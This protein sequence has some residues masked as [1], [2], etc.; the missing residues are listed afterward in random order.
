MTGNEAQ[1]MT[2]NEAQPMTGNEAQPMIRPTMRAI[3]PLVDSHVH[4]DRYSDD[5]VMTMLERAAE[6]GVTRLLTV[7]VDLPTSRAALRLAAR[8]P[9]VLAAVGIHP[10]RLAPL[11]S[12]SEP[13]EA[14]QGLVE[15][16][17]SDPA[18]GRP[19]AIGEIG[20]DDGAPDLAV[21]AR[22][23]DRC[24]GLAADAQLPV[25]LHVVGQPETHLAALEIVARHPTVRTVAHYFVSDADLA[26][27]Y[28]ETG[29]WIAV[30]K[31]VTRTAEVA[32]REAL[33]VIPPDRLLLETDTYPLP[34]RTTEPRDVAEICTAVAALTH[35][36]YDEVA[37]AT[38]AAFDA[39][40]GRADQQTS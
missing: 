21:Q 2:G 23:L 26:H 18:G 40:I 8:R 16:S 32:V 34:G 20:L 37:A 27:R 36:T 4:L 17:L 38:T 25:V 35:R 15:A 39:F 13:V 11:A 28:V 7:G 3:P 9:S 19:A 31:P 10:T 12:T 14:F 5:T 33:R 1:P 29:C 22:F 6:R 30:G 24:L